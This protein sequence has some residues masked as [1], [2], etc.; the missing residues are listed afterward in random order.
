M[1]YT[2]TIRVEFNHC[3][4]AG[5][6]FYPRFFEMTNSVAENFFREV[7]QHPYEAMM[8]QGQGVPTAA[9][10]VSFHAPTRLGEELEWRMGITRL[11]RSSIGLH[12]EAHC[13]GTHRVTADLTLVFVS[14]SGRPE[15]WPEKVRDHITKFMEAA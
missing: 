12:L 10:Q 7:A 15:P 6:M 2:R 4:P 8:A 11:G 5:I 9:M 14:S 13:G 1:L 3:D